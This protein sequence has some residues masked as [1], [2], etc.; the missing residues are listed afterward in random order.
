MDTQKNHSLLNDFSRL[1]TPYMLQHNQT[2]GHD[3]VEAERSGDSFYDADG[4][5]FIDCDSS[6]GIFN[7]GRRQPA[8]KDELLRALNETDQGNFPMISIEKAALAEKLA[9]FVPGDLECSV[10][11]VTRGES[12]DFACK[13]ARGVTQKTELLFL[14]GSWF[15]HTGFALSL[16]DLKEK[17]IFGP[18]IPGTRKLPFGCIDALK[19]TITKNTAAIFIEPVQSENGCRSA[20]SDYLKKLSQLCNDTGALLVVD[21]TQTGI[22]RTGKKFAFEHAGILP[23]ILV[24]GEAL[25]AGM[26]PIAAT[27]FNQ[28]LNRFMNAHPMIH[29]STF[30]GSDLGCRAALTA[31]EEYER[32]MPWENADN[33]GTIL[34][35]ELNEIMQDY[36][37]IIRNIEGSGLLISM[38]CVTEDIAELFCKT[39]AS[40]G[41]F[42]CRGQI[43]KESVIFRPSLLISEDRI[44]EIT[45]LTRLTIKSL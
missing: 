14:E 18:L 33:A 41:L 40:N 27:V 15:G 6:S 19:E 13:L 25:G 8:I 20:D 39:A 23:D 35:T 42:I 21:E 7:L 45:R 12:I 9:E 44:H 10:F 11:S 22:G 28:K 2:D 31:L 30:G 34:L 16:S 38:E 43:K 17:K 37:D 3:I 5:R 29:L 32:L 4:N 24:I 26:F 1:F 36:P